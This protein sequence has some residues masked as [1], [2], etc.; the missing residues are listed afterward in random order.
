V[1][2]QEEERGKDQEKINQ[3]KERI[4]EL[5]DQGRIKNLLEVI[6][7]QEKDIDICIASEKKRKEIL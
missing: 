4:K 3:L 2:K 5:T 6:K 1:E 7:N